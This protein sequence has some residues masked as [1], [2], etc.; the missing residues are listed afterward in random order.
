MTL[1]QYNDTP[2]GQRQSFCEAIYSNVPP[3]V[4]ND[5]TLCRCPSWQKNHISFLYWEF[6]TFLKFTYELLLKIHVRG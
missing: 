1:S 5:N 2:S 4:G 6:Y 3:Y